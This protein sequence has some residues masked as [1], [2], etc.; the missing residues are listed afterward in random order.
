LR[1]FSPTVYHKGAW[2]LHMLRKQVG[3]NTFFAILRRHLSDNRYGNSSIA[4]FRAVAQQVA[5]QDLSWFFD[6][7][8]DGVGYPVFEYAFETRPGSA[9]GAAPWVVTLYLHQ[10]QESFGVPTFAIPLEIGVRTISGER[11]FTVQLSGAEDDVFSFDLDAQPIGVAIDPDAWMLKR[12]SPRSSFA[13]TLPEPSGVVVENLY[14]NP[15]HGGTT[16]VLR[17]PHHGLASTLNGQTTL[18]PV[19]VEVFDPRGRRL[20][21]LVSAPF[22]PGV[23]RMG[24]DG[25]DDSG[26]QLAGGVYLLRVT[27]PSGTN[28]RRLVLLP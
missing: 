9:S 20:R 7:W 25:R 26:R 12:V 4:A 8:V 5:G 2:V 19:R 10:T 11:R 27:S 17:V 6:Q 1:L 15:A 18:F 21:T 28:S 14:P 3:D 16:L 13:D 22:G 24:F 23:Y